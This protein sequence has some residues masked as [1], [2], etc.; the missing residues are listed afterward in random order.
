LKKD[1][2]CLNN[3]FT[4]FLTKEIQS[5]SWNESSNDMINKLKIENKNLFIEIKL[6]QKEHSRND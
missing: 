4:L 5:L 6:W 3:I 1:F 2:D